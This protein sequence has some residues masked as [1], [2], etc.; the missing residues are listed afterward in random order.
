VIAHRRQLLANVAVLLSLALAGGGGC[1][2]VSGWV[3]KSEG[4]GGLYDKV[5]LTYRTPTK[6]VNALAAS[7]LA[8]GQPGTQLASY[9]APA[10]PVVPDNVA[11]ILEITYPHPSDKPGY[12]LVQVTVSNGNDIEGAKPLSPWEKFLGVRSDDEPLLTGKQ[13]TYNVDIPRA[14]LDQLMATLREAG[15]FT[16]THA[17]GPTTRLTTRLDGL[18]VNKN[19]TQVPQLDDL[20]IRAYHQGRQARLAAA[21]GIQYNAPG[22]VAGSYGLPATNSPGP[23]SSVQAY[24]DVVASDSARGAPPAP[25]NA[26]A[27]SQP[28]GVA[29]YATPQ[30]GT[31]PYAAPQYGGPAPAGTATGQTPVARLPEVYSPVN[32]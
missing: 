5:S 8:A 19:W 30:Y 9:Q 26:G 32:R 29:Q 2:T 1:S 12:A 7:R 22:Q 16:A 13:T 27:V 28:Y 24:R 17:E 23:L 21:A 25:A 14:E 4:P 10:A 6:Q 20:F 11:G 15:Y 18:R 31:P 3:G